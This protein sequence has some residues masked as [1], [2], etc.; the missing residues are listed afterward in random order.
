MNSN[1]FVSELHKCSSDKASMA[2]LRRLFETEHHQGL[3]LL[4]RFGVP[5]SDPVASLPFKALA[6]VFAKHGGSSAPGNLG[7]SLKG[8]RSV[9]VETNPFDKRFDAMVSCK[10]LGIMVRTHLIRAVQQLPSEQGI[11][12]PMLLDDLQHWSPSVVNRWIEGYYTP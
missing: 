9:G 10:T 4:A 6:Y 7:R 11:N 2:H 3:A 1:D 12:Y 8:I 5:V